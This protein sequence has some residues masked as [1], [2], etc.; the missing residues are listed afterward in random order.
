[1]N[2]APADRRRGSHPTRLGV[3]L[4]AALVLATGCS[5]ASEET[6][7]S[8][9]A[10]AARAPDSTSE[11]LPGRAADVYLPAR[12]QRSTD[13]VP[14][15]LLV[16]GGGWQ[17]AD[18]TGLAPLA[19][20]LADAGF[21]AVNATY[22]AGADGSVFPEPVQDVLCASGFAVEQARTAG[23]VPG[24]LVALGHSAGGHLASLAALQGAE[25]AGQCPYP[26][27]GITGLIGLAGVYDAMAFE[28]ALVDLF[29]GTPSEQPMAWSQGDP[30]G[31]VDSGRVPQDLEVLLLHGDADDDVPLDQSRAFDGALRRAGVPVRL[32]VVPGA[33]HQTIYT[34]PVAGPVAITWIR[35]LA[36]G[37]SSG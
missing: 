14:I 28:F 11:Y 20:D 23:M 18:R 6:G 15:V 37:R 22:R 29:G 21:V 7:A 34:A 9:A 16:P 10:D 19:A 25:L 24:P 1:M 36:A 17:T 2:R 35:Q 30:V 13:P 26:V 5:S 31:L 27:P 8:S 4:L 33:T 12:E 32:E 3:G